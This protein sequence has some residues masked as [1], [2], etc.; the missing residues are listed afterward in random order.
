MEVSIRAVQIKD[1][2][3]I[4]RIC[5][6][7]AVLEYMVFLPSM[8]LEAMENRIRSL[9]HNQY[10]Y[11]AELDG[12]VVGFVGLTQGQGRR[13]HSGDIFIGVDSQYHKKGIGKA[14]LTKILDLADNWLMLER[15][16]LGV[17]VT[18][19]GAQALYE[20][21]G[22]SVEGKKKGSLKAHGTF[23]DEIIMSRISPNGL[24]SNSDYNGTVR[25][26]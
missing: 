15:V 4:H 18:N 23:V 12:N 10:E 25:I 3:V 6:Q 2:E 22:F 7:E 16:E 9:N 21:F 13:S 1:A 11:V 26:E 20:K 14:L 24:L 19:P 17:L 8:R 5:T